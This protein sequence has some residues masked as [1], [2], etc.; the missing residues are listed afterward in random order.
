M[1]HGAMVEKVSN[2]SLIAAAF[3]PGAARRLYPAVGPAYAREP[4]ALQ[5][6]ERVAYPQPLDRVEISATLGRVGVVREPGAN[7]T[8]SV[9]GGRADLLT[10]A[11]ADPE[12]QP[13]TRANVELT[14]E[15]QA[16]VEELQRRDR[17]VRR[18]EQAHI[19]AGGGYA[20]GAQFELET[21]PDG[22]RYAVGG[23]VAIDTS[24]VAGDPA[25]TIRKMQVVRR[26]A[27]APAE[28]SSQDRGVAAQAQAI[29]REARAEL[30]RQRAEGQ[31]ARDDNRLPL[32]GPASVGSVSSASRP[33]ADEDAAHGTA[34][35]SPGGIV[36]AAVRPH[37]AVRPRA[38][39]VGSTGP[40][41]LPLT[42]RPMPL[43]SYAASTRP[44]T[45]L[46]TS[47]SR[48]DLV[49]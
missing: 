38:D 31:Q 29:E 46:N 15:Q 30:R 4:V 45:T 24:A 1:R 11:A 3:G 2:S 25:A 26:A 14:P 34:S 48:L 36:Q 39:A 35:L 7:A 27:L 37:E 23:E 19:V 8:A 32:T 20:R 17:E 47:G 18:H 21:G 10:G 9:S 16:Q 6:I 41:G 42:Q 5:P 28:P 44:F 43:R 40:P 13:V 49:A 12:S 22:K 33:D